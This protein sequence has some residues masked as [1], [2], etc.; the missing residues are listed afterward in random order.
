MWLCGGSNFTEIIVTRRA[1]VTRT[2]RRPSCL[3]SVRLCLRGTVTLSILRQALF[4]WYSDFV[5]LTS[6]IV[7]MIQWLCRF[8]QREK[9]RLD[10]N[11]FVLFV[12]GQATWSVIKETS[13]I[14]WVVCYKLTAVWASSKNRSLADSFSE[15]YRVINYVSG[16]RKHV[17]NQCLEL[18]AHCRL[19]TNV[20]V[21]E[22]GGGGWRWGGGGGGSVI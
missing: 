10:S 8:R 3:H 7:F 12:Q 13:D 20:K 19:R 17:V 15:T 9:F 14:I 18:S 5:D 4:S 16:W 6:G 21:E 11:D 2:T 1:G 22:A